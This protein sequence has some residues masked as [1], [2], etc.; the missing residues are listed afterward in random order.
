MFPQPCF[1]PPLIETE[2]LILRGHVMADLAACQRLWS[3][4]TVVRYLGGRAFSQEEVW[5]RLLR[6]AGGWAQLG[7]G[8]WLVETKDGRFVGE[9]GFHELHRDTEPSFAGIPEVGWILAPEWHGKGVAGEAM[10][11]ALA[12]GDRHI[13]HPRFACIIHPEN[14]PSIRLGERLGFIFETEIR[15]RDGRMRLSYRNRSKV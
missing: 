10:T 4:A 2:R 8:F 13:D 1:P 11:A 7:F 15:Y 12:W 9:V 6:Y 5:M 14:A 3:D